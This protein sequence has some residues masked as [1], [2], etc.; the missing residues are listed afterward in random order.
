MTNRI[1]IVCGVGINDIPESTIYYDENNK[2]K[3]YPFYYVW[4]SMLTRC[5][6]KNQHIK[7]P[8]YI[9]TTVCDEWK[10][11]KSFKDW[12]D[13]NYKSGYHLDKDILS[14]GYPNNVYSPHTCIFIPKWL[15]TFIT[16]RNS[17][18]GEY[19]LG[20]STS[21][22]KENPYTSYCNNPLTG[23]SE[24]LG[25]FK[26]KEEAHDIWVKK[27]LYHL[28]NMKDEICSINPKLF[29]NLILIIKN[30]K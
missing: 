28:D 10:S 29:D 7:F 22:R 12:F 18:R 25:S 26:T 1:K 11:L 17:C 16:F 15:N 2:K 20:V 13:K 14:Y 6:D 4:Q 30:S 24:Y 5:Y 27:K 8:S 19:P 21:N 9:G 3:K 23:K